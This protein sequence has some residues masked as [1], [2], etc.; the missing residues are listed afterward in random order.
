MAV[1][2][3]KTINRLRKPTLVVT[4]CSAGKRCTRALSVRSLPRGTLEQTADAW[5]G[6]LKR[7]TQLQP[8]ADLYKGRA[9]QMAR[10]AAEHVSGRFAVLSAGLGYVKSETPIPGYDLTIRPVGPA[11]VLRK[12]KGEVSAARWWTHVSKGP[13]SSTLAKDAK[14]C[15]QVLV[16]LSRAYAAMIEKELIAVSRMEGVQLRLFGLSI[17]NHLCHALK[18]YVMPYDERLD[19][20][21][22][23]GTRVD[24]PQRAL[25]DFVTNISPRSDGTLETDRKAVAARL[26][27]VA[28]RRPRV[29]KRVSDD[30]IRRMVTRLMP[31][32]G[33]TS[34]MVLRH[35]RNVEGVSCEQGRFS[36]I[37]NDVRRGL[38]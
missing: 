27:P 25:L 38:S 7:E 2:R 32:V 6:R 1:S 21:G 33:P 37:Y 19:R 10:K 18:P 23:P 8:A 20:L 13:F 34:N 24:F 15:S 11:S 17:S 26:A 16:C 35:L 3:T 12:I 28:F 31:K 30:E 4:T 9:F 5:I 14:G 36:R 29:Q 22:R